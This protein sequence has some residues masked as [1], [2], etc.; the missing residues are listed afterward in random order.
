M[1][2]IYKHSTPELCLQAVDTAQANLELVSPLS[3]SVSATASF[4]HHHNW[5]NQFQIHVPNID[6][7]S[8]WNWI[9]LH[10]PLETQGQ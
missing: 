10:L 6:E 7:S 8:L 1:I 3:S 5:L 2:M 4:M 9:N